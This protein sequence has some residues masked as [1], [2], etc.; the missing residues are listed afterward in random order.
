MKGSSTRDIV[1]LVCRHLGL[2]DDFANMY[3]QAAETVIDTI[4]NSELHDYVDLW[5]Q[6]IPDLTNET[7]VAFINYSKLL[8]L[9]TTIDH[10]AYD[11][12]VYY[13]AII[14]SVAL[15]MAVSFYFGY[16]ANMDR[17][18][19]FDQFISGLDFEESE[20]E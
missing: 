7:M 10:P 13:T 11:S 2:E 17:P 9:G 8:I 14:D 16:M 15:A 6:T 20:E 12:E 5:L 19:T 18:A 1:D 3:K 4:H